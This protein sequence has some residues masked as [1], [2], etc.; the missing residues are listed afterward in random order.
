MLQ[1]SPTAPL[2]KW[3]CVGLI[4]RFVRYRWSALT[5]CSL[6]L[7]FVLLLFQ[8]RWKHGISDGRIQSS[9]PQQFCPKLDQAYQN[10]FCT[11]AFLIQVPRMTN[12]RGEICEH[13]SQL[14]ENYFYISLHFLFLTINVVEHW[15]EYESAFVVFSTRTHN[16]LVDIHVAPLQPTVLT[17]VISFCSLISFPVSWN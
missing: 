14:R 16:K 9:F 17:P 2:Q 3:L 13:N 8:G 11:I 4:R 12:D 6:P 5:S 7:C 15:H 10:E 1:A